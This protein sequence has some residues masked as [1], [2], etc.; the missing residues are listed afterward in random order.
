MDIT[1]YYILGSLLVDVVVILGLLLP[2]GEGE[3][4]RSLVCRVFFSFA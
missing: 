1:V 4:E 2:S 3:R